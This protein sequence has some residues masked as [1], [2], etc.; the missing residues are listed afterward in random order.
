MRER[1]ALAPLAMAA[2]GD[3]RGGRTAVERAE[4]A[5][6]MRS[7]APALFRLANNCVCSQSHCPWHA[8][9]SRSFN[10]GRLSTSND[11]CRRS[12]PLHTSTA[13]FEIIV[14]MLI[15]SAR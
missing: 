9:A 1:Q 11:T 12:G 2:P 4:C 7:L 13:Y 15:V 6:S 5:Q 10:A 3:P 8:P 14:L